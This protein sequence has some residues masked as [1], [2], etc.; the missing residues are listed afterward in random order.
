MDAKFSTKDLN[1]IIATKTGVATQG[2]SKYS[3]PVQF[4]SGGR[5]NLI[6]VQDDKNIVFY[7]EKKDFIF[8]LM[9]NPNI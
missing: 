7:N 5:K 4:F 6:F 9:M 3:N 1:E 2:T 8:V